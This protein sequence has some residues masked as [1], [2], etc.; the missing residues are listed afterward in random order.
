MPS[1]W[2]MRIKALLDGLDLKTALQPEQPWL[3]WARAR[4]AIN[5]ERRIKISAPEPRPALEYRPRRMSVTRVEDWITNPYAIF[6][7]QIL[8]LQPLPALGTAPD[9]SLR[10]G[11]VHE[12]LSRF[13]T[14]HPEHLPADIRGTLSKIA[15]DVLEDY[16]G[17][18]RVAA[19]WLPRLERFL[20]WFADTEPARRNGIRKV[21]A[22]TQGSLVI[23]GPAGPFTLTAR[24]DRIDDGN[25]GLVITDYKTGM[26]PNSK[27]VEANRAPQLPLEAAIALGGTGFPNLS[28]RPVSA[29]C[30]IRASGGEPPGEEKRID[31]LPPAELAAKALKGLEDLIADFDNPATPYRAIRRPGFRYDYDDYAHLARVTEWSA[32][33]DEEA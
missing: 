11:L 31:S 27:A 10:G 30:Y 2:L 18:P 5:S 17:H 20:G 24:A 21:I 3:S 9:Q 1:R 33:V 28:G 22:E 12:V 15:E 26:I 25:D 6:A 29:L 4:D 19:F 14:L 7:G 16:T 8:K 13:S 23:A 32:H